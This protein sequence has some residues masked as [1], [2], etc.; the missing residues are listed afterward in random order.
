[1]TFNY[2][3]DPG[4]QFSHG[5]LIEQ[6]MVDALL[7]DKKVIVEKLLKK[8]VVS[9]TKKAK[10]SEKK[11][12]IA[13]VVVANKTNSSKNY[14]AKTAIAMIRKMTDAASVSSFSKGDE[15]VTVK[16]AASSKIALLSKK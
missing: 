10:D 4:N 8:G 15:R 14:N 9:T 11:T 12:T 16:A 2:F 1:M 13:K 3:V 7:A 6:K 5:K